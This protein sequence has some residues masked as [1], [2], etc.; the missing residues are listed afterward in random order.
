MRYAIERWKGKFW[1]VIIYTD[2]GERI[3]EVASLYSKA[4]LYINGTLSDPRHGA[5]FLELA[6]RLADAAEGG[7]QVGTVRAVVED[8]LASFGG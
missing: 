2:E 1:K 4:G 6:H 5:L 3:A 8:S 7:S